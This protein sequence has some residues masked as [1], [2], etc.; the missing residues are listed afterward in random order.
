MKRAL[1]A[2]TNVD[3]QANL[4]TVEDK[5]VQKVGAITGANVGNLKQL[6]VPSQTLTY[7]PKIK[8]ASSGVTD[9]RLTIPKRYKIPTV[10]PGSFYT[11]ST[12]AYPLATT[13]L[14]HISG[15]ADE[16]ITTD[17]TRYSLYNLPTPHSYRMYRSSWQPDV[18]NTGFSA[19]LNMATTEIY[20]AYFTTDNTMY[21]FLENRRVTEHYVNEAG[22]E[23]PMPTGFT[24][25][26]QTVIDSDTY[27]FK[28]AK[29]LPFSYF[30]NNKAYR[31]KGWYK[32][33]TKP[34]VLET[35]RTPEYDTTFDDNDDLTVV[36][37]EIKYGGNAVT[38][39]FVGED[40][41]LLQPTGFQVTTDIVETIDGLSTVLSNV[42]AVDSTGNVKTL[43]IPQ[44]EYVLTPQMNF[45]GTKNSLIT[46]PRQYQEI[47]FTKPAN[48][49]GLDYPV[50]GRVEN[51]FSGNLYVEGHN[52]LTFLLRKSKPINTK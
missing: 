46:I 38:F 45:Y 15:Q 39:G 18:T 52:H 32:G 40:G 5:V 36:Y 42:S 10:T 49:Q 6:T 35:S 21:Y 29:E 26:N 31:F 14:R 2:P 25:G 48:Y 34:K 37:E 50:A 43:T 8:V 23:V 41:Q 47:S 12:T 28:L 17:G 7:V 9:F 22:A 13:L 4:T 19:T 33:K 11:G 16:R 20:P 1:V 27:H 3:I 51:M 30:L 44:K 24:Q